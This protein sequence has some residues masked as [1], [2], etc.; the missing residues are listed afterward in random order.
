MT[1]EEYAEQTLRNEFHYIDVRMG[2]SKR[3]YFY[4]SQVN[5]DRAVHYLYVPDRKHLGWMEKKTLRHECGHIIMF[6]L[7]LHDRD[8]LDRM[9]GAMK[10]QRTWCMFQRTWYWN[11]LLRWVRIKLG[12][13]SKLDYRRGD[14]SLIGYT[15]GDSELFADYFAMKGLPNEY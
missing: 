8:K 14:E 15:H 7:Y 5:E 6:E 10:S 2:L 4:T 9:L 11:P 3:G 12:F 13:S 1:P